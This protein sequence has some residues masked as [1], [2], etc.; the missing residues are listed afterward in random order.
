MKRDTITNVLVFCGLIGLG[1]ATR[2]M[3]DVFKPA[4][5]NFTATGAAALFAGYYFRN[6]LPA[7]LVPLATIA[8]S[9]FALAPFNNVGEFIVVYAALI[10]GV[11][12][13]ILV[14]HKYN[15]ATVIGGGLAA[16]ISF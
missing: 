13:G 1:V 14:R 11:V 6:L 10:V 3:S 15:F 5:S 9:N 12:L 2:W 4:F 16:S 8:I 7:V